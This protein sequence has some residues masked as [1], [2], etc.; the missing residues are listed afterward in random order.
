LEEAD[1]SCPAVGGS[2]V[3]E[4]NQVK[5]KRNVPEIDWEATFSQ[6]VEAMPGVLSVLLGK[7]LSPG[8]LSQLSEIEK[9]IPESL[10]SL[11]E[12]KSL[13]AIK[14]KSVRNAELS[15][16]ADKF[17]KSIISDIHP[18][19]L[20]IDYLIERLEAQA[21]PPAMLGY[22]VETSYL[23]SAKTLD[24]L[25][26]SI[27]SAGLA[28]KLDEFLESFDKDS[29]QAILAVGQLIAIKLP[30][31]YKLLAKPRTRHTRKAAQDYIS[32]YGDLTGLLEK[33]LPL[34]VGLVELLQGKKPSYSEI[35]KRTLAKNI[36]VVRVS[37]YSNLGPNFDVR[38]IRNAIAHKSFYLDPVNRK[39]KFD[40]PISGQT[41]ELSYRELARQTKELSALVLILH[42][43]RFKL[44]LAQLRNFA[45][46]TTEC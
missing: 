38:L 42:Q 25:I 24:D 20:G 4:D 21:V 17:L 34:V 27:Y 2:V 41:K 40:D 11:R 18:D 23:A 5:D 28:R 19:K 29:R 26:E 14:D 33:G 16:V 13:Q 37:S 7:K 12:L 15:R 45:K 1:V 3:E 8:I 10:A 6:L 32:I 31:S 36:K 9:S 35:A 30:R 39:V 44:L 46:I 22:L 43:V